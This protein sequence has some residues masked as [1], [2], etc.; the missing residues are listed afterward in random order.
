MWWISYR[1]NRGTASTTSASSRTTAPRARCIRCSSIHRRPRIR[2]TLRAASHWWATTSTS[3]TR[4]ARIATLRSTTGT[5]TP[6]ASRRCSRRPSRLRRWCTPSTWSWGTMVAS[7]SP[8]R[9][10]TPWCR[11]C[12]RPANPHR[13]PRTSASN[14]PTGS[15]SP[16]R[17][18]RPARGAFPSTVTA[19][20]SMCH[21]LSASRWCSTSAA[22]HATRCAA[23][24]CTESICT[25]RTKPATQ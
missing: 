17:S 25:W 7:T 20:R 4:G 19:R 5:A 21:R 8:A 12:R 11:L 1:G 13:W 18:S 10:R 3:R 23:S 22:S 9:I 14:I 16:A 6:S 2:C 24:S 15:F